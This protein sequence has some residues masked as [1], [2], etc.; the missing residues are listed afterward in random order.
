MPTLNSTPHR[1][2]DGAQGVLERLAAAVGVPLGGGAGRQPAAGAVADAVVGSGR[3]R[4]LLERAIGGI[5]RGSS[6]RQA[7]PGT[8]GA[9]ALPARAR[10]MRAGGRVAA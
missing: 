9:R 1:L 3:Q 7:R 4:Q 10:P 2:P 8:G 6:R 5:V